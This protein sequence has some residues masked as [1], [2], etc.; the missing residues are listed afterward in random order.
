MHSVISFTPSAPCYGQISIGQSDV[1]LK[2]NHAYEGKERGRMYLMISCKFDYKL[3]LWEKQVSHVMG[4]VHHV[5]IKIR[6]QSPIHIQITH[7]SQE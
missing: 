7:K 6:G 1:W 4:D 2:K 5:G 3:E